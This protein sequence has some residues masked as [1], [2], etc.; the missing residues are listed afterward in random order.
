M[1]LLIAALFPTIVCAN[2]QYAQ[3]IGEMCIQAVSHQTTGHLEHHNVCVNL[4]V[5]ET[6]DNNRFIT[7]EY[8]I[9]TYLNYAI[10]ID[11]STA[12]FYPKSGIVTIPKLKILRNLPQLKDGK[13]YDKW[14][15]T[16]ELKAII[17]FRGNGNFVANFRD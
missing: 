4:K 2:S 6:Y 16:G 9:I 17:E 5:N 1:K 7:G 8:R 3:E 11:E 10:P 12:N 15:Y 14:V 13:L